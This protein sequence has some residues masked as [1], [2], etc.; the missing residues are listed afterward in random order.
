MLLGLALATCPELVALS[1]D[2]ATLTT[3]PARYYAGDEVSLQ[4]TVRADSGEK[5]VPLALRPGSGLSAQGEASDPE[6]RELRIGKSP[7][8]WVLTLRFVP[9][10]PGPGSIPELRLKGLRVPA[11]GYSAAS[12]LGP[13]ER[14]PQPPRPQRDLPGTAFYLALFAALLL[15]L[16]ALGLVVALWLV[17]A[18]RSRLA[19]RRA[20]LAFRRLERSLDYLESEI[21]SA[22]P[23]SYY[24]ALS[25]A[26]RLYLAARALPEA[27]ALTAAEI[28]RLPEGAFPA[29]ATKARTVELFSLA[30]RVRYGGEGYAEADRRA[31]LESAAEEAR[32][33][34]N[35]T[36]EALLARV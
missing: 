30:D 4:A 12:I 14:D 36:E 11:I 27:L 28:A 7:E 2:S 31:R 24:A 19:T 18:A 6:L 22:D 20:A 9:W 29:P 17:P 1:L 26:L 5:L 15:V 34:G 25:R 16:A 33:I 35:E 13:D 3:I 8:G 23:A 10:S 21:G 32:A